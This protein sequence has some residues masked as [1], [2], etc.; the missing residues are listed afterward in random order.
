MSFDQKVLVTGA[1]G[2]LG[3]QLVY[4]LVRRNIRPIAHVRKNSDTEYVD[5]IGLE[6]RYADLRVREE[7]QSLMQ[8]V[9][10]VIHTAAFVNFRRDRLTQF[11]GINTFGA[12]NL[13]QCAAASGVK[14]F[15]HVSTVAAVGA[16]TRRGN[17]TKG[18][19]PPSVSEK[20]TF[21]LG[22]LHIPYILSKRA[23]EEELFRTAAKGGPELVVINPSII[24]APSRTRDDRRKAMKLFSR[25]F[26][27]DF[28]NWIN[29]VDIRDVAPAIVEALEKGNHCERYILAGDNITLR[30]LVLSVSAILDKVPHLVRP[31]RPLVDIAARLSLWYSTVIR[32]G[33]VSFYP[34][35]VKMVDFDWAFSSMKARRELGFNSRSV[36]I[37]LQDLLT[38][39]FVGTYLKPAQ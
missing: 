22:S 33:K 30:D 29:L 28:P 24:M 21:N 37:T 13:Y 7:L 36:H 16:R 27:P 39:N 8:G 35:L 20:H 25:P 15:V 38:N 34:D 1:S 11:T 17:N 23:A 18:K 31:P 12:L 9:D 5:S 32:R 19:E 6:K 4:E 3:K 14:R 10:K 2:S 26:M